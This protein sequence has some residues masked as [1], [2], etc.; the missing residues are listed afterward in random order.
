MRICPTKATAALNLLAIAAAVWLYCLNKIAADPVA[1][2]PDQPSLLQALDS[3]A[4]N[5]PF[6]RFEAQIN[7]TNIRLPAPPPEAAA[8]RLPQVAVSE[9]PTSKQTM[10]APAPA[11]EP[12]L[13]P[14]VPQP[15]L[16]TTTPIMPMIAKPI[17]VWPAKSNQVAVPPLTVSP[18]QPTPT[19]LVRF[20][21][22]APATPMT[23]P[24]LRP[25]TEPPPQ[26][27][28]LLQSPL[29]QS[30]R[31][32]TR[33]PQ[34]T[35]LQDLHI[36]QANLLKG[37]QTLDIVANKGGL[38]MEIFWPD[39]ARQSAYLYDV[40]TR[41]FGM[42]SAVLNVAGEMVSTAGKVHANHAGLSPLIRQLK[43]PASRGEADV[44]AKI[45]TQHHVRGAYTPVRIFTK[46]VDARLV[47]GIAQLTGK[48]IGPNSVLRADYVID[49]GR[50]FVANI[51]HD[52]V[53][54]AGRVLLVDG[55]C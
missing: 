5:R 30:L 46:S 52:G 21:A 26:Q 2:L 42:R 32:Q 22:P 31:S 54:A 25:I 13:V 14:L 53:R 4:P 34:M 8:M 45:V 7:M 44:I 23:A 50:V 12:T 20:A 55:G 49:R 9:S 29:L 1:S 18:V 3:A 17:D 35:A 48:S 19:A 36:R 10:D 15:A 43:Q 16:D 6:D 28:P 33:A 39:T 47:D 38:D 37:Q 24:A 41:C 40:M 27:T 51:T 11:V